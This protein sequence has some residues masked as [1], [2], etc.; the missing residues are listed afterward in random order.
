M[1]GKGWAPE[2]AATQTFVVMDAIRA[3]AALLVVISHVRDIVLL[4]W[5]GGGAVAR[6]LYVVTGFGHQAVILFFVLSGFWIAKTVAARGADLDTGDY[7]VDRLSRLWMVIVP[8]V[9]LTWLL[10]TIGI[11]L[12]GPALYVG[13]WGTHSILDAA[14]NLGA[15]NILGSLAFLQKIVVPPIGSNGPLWST[16]YEFWYYLWYPVIVLA[17]RRRVSILIPSLLLAILYPAMLIGFGCWLMGAGLYLARQ[18]YPVAGIGAARGAGLVG[19]ILMAAAILVA[20]MGL[21]G[22]P[23]DLLLGAG[24]ALLLAMLL[25]APPSIALP[26]GPLA[27]Y[28]AAS[29]FS[30]YAI[31]YPIAALLASSILSGRLPFGAASVGLILAIALVCMIVAAFFSRVTEA[32]TGRVRGAIKRRLGLQ[33]RLQESVA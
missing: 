31:H 13:E 1:G 20:R 21:V 5:P 11:R 33:P 30:L 19:A 7:L 23:I 3:L 16:A 10:D 27:R 2:A 24:F 12:N 26:I 14:D 6:L 9:A 15:A 25:W 18:R 8:T 28:G 4:D 17:L 22:E 29:S 32:Q